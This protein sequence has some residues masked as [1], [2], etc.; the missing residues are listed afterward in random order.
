MYMITTFFTQEITRKNKYQMRVLDKL[1][2]K[3]DVDK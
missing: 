3:Q 2:L 1:L